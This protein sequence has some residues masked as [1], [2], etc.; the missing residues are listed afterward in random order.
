MTVLANTFHAPHIDYKALSPLIATVGGSCVVL[1]VGL[2]R[3]RFMQR[4]LVPA[5]TLASLG[6]AIALAVINW[7]VGDTKPIVA[8]ALASDSLSLALSI[9]FY[10]AGIAAVVLSLRSPAARDAGRGEYYSLLLG[11]ISGMVVLASAENLI[12]LFVGLELLSIPLYVLCA[13]RVR[14]EGSLEAGLKYLIIGSFG[15][16]TLLYGL[17]LIYGSTGSTDFSRIAAANGPTVSLTDP[18]LLTR[19]A[20]TP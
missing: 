11:S 10:V 12:T 19:V 13:S 20:L 16:A 18:L 15:S 5:L 14:R 6:G 17:A 9:L 8:G 3:Q 1:M 7:K 2:F 4:A